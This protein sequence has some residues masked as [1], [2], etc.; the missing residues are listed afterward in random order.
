MTSAPPSNAT[1]TPEP[2]PVS[3]D[4]LWRRTKVLASLGPATDAPGVLD[5]M[6][7][8][9][10]N[11]VRINCSHGTPDD[12]RRRAMEARAAGERAGRPVGVLLDLQGP[13]VRLSRG[14][15]VRD[16]LRGDCLTFVAGEAGEGE[17]TIDWGALGTTAEA[18]RSEIVIG[19]GTPR[20]VV[21]TVDHE[22]GRVTARC[23]MPGRIQPRKGVT[24]TYSNVGGPALTDKDLADLD[25]AAEVDVDFVALSFVREARDVTRLRA[26]LVARGS[27]AR[28]IAKIERLQAL[29]NLEEIIEVSD[30][31]MVARGDLGVEAGV[32]RIALMQKRIID[33]A[34]AAGKVCITATQMLESMITAPEPTRA[35][36]LDVANAVLDGT[37]A[38]M[39]SAETAVG[40]D[41]AAAVR[42]MAE[43]AAEAERAE[44]LYCIYLDQV[45]TEPA[46]A[47]MKAAVVLGRDL[48]AGLL[49]VPTESGG[50]ARATAK[51]RPRRPIVALAQDTRV[52]GR[53]TL[54]WGIV[55]G[56]HDRVEGVDDLIGTA[57]ANARRI[58]GLVDE[59]TVVLT[60]SGGV[61]GDDSMNLI[62]V[63]HLGDSS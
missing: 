34:T 47:V 16:L 3:P 58:T 5:D 23:V 42:A 6:V 62:V 9:G 45:P 50:S 37:S 52:A 21:E 25:L 26:E 38:L 40:R 17:I 11:A 63:R 7:D 41:P 19:D 15:Q 59:T 14:E 51:Y 36:A 49:V 43:I 28:V 48:A 31:V 57:L 4:I 33:A 56:T 54:D 29:E 32:A 1:D 44:Q 20:L 46:E 24:V 22:A 53:L 35:E 8:A 10:L 13:K 27:G 39:L 12:H 18:G 55:P 61:A 60:T 2:H 30:G